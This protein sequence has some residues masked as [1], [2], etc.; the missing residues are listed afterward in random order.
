MRDSAVRFALL[1]V[2]LAACSGGEQ[3][4]AP[5]PTAAAAEGE[6]APARAT[7][8][9]Q[10]RDAARAEADPSLPA[11]T[12]RGVIT[13]AG[14]P[15]PRKPIAMGGVAGCQHDGE[16]LTESV[17]ASGGKLANVFV[18][19]KDG[20]AAEDVPPPP[21]EPAVLDQRGCVYVPHVLGVRAGQPLVIHNGDPA[22]HNVNARPKRPKNE[23]FNKVQPPQGADIQV[24]FPE[25]EVAIS[26]EC[27]LHPWMRSWVAVV[28]NPFFAVSAAD[29][30]FE[31]AGLPPGRY[32]LEAWH[33]VYG[34]RS[35]P[36]EVP[37]SGGARVEIG[38]TAK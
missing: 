31:I 21:V 34:R 3:P 29:G 4:E 28:E 8:A 35:L 12:V 13:L 26:F 11:G 10:A 36:V 37:E 33:E 2:L 32:V 1:A 9:G 23:A 18:R 24:V 30:G 38:Y 14:T 20:L 6:E 22:S 19:V 15:P 17:V 25:P 27:N 16:V 7:P 5:A